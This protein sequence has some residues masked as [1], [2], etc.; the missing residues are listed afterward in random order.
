M[1]LNVSEAF[2]NAPPGT[3]AWCCYAEKWVWT[4]VYEFKILLYFSPWI[5]WGNW[6]RGEEGPGGLSACLP[7]CSQCWEGDGLFPE[8]HLLFPALLSLSP[9]SGCQPC[10]GLAAAEA[11]APIPRRAGVDAGDMGSRVKRKPQREAGGR[12]KDW[13][14]PNRHPAVPEPEVNRVWLGEKRRNW[15]K[16]SK[17][18]N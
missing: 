4:S 18:Q 7:R 5:Y 17:T 12:R 8:L 1:L 3:G 10:A 6:Q 14:D 16:S 13:C 2:L 15:N 11:T 9:R